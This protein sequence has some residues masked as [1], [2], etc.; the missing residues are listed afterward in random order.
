MSVRKAF[1]ERF[2]SSPAVC[3]RAP[4]RVNLIGEHIDYNGGHVL[5]IAIGKG[6]EIAASPRSDGV[7][8]LYAQN[9]A[10][11]YEG[12]VPAERLS[13]GARWAN[14]VLGVVREME[15]LGHAC[16]GMD[17]VVGGDVPTASGLS[18]S[19]ALEVAM[20][21]TLCHLFGIDLPRKEVALLALR[22]EN[23]F[24][25]VNCGIMDQAASA[26]CRAGHALLL[27]CSTVEYRHVPMTAIEERAAVLVAHCGVRRGLST[28]AYNARREQ[29]DR[30]LD[31]LREK[32]RPIESLCAATMADLESAREFLDPTVFRRAR[33]AIGEEE[34]VNR[35]LP[36]LEGGRLEEL[37]ALL[38]ASHAS[39]RDDYEVSSPE[40]E[41]LVAA[42]RPQA[43]VHGS[44]LTGAGFGGCT[45]SLVD[46]EA[47]DGVVDALIRR[48]YEPK[49]IEPI[50]FVT[51]AHDGVAV[52]E[53]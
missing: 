25:G 46:R 42:I 26:C 15:A 6:V 39:L 35:A 40:L 8:R 48:Y 18:S 33:H 31:V 44:R 52:V 7:F 34:R 32:V 16:G 27:D 9:Y 22:A 53:S 10:E 5:P 37:G 49:G 23:R 17:A 50:V 4:G 28:S 19:A 13:S 1:E 12:P 38:D 21:W 11:R 45:V 43:G 47:V 36:A 30:A 2:G 29:C 3:V 24:V 51:Q 14:Y 20:A 41:D